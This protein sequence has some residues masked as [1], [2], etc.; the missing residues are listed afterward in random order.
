MIVE[1]NPEELMEQKQLAQEDDSAIAKNDPLYIEEII[2]NFEGRRLETWKGQEPD[3]DILKIYLEEAK[4]LIDSSS[5]HLQEFRSNNSDLAA[6]Q[7]LQRELHTIKGGARM[8][9]AEGIATL[10]HEM[11]T[12]YEEL[13][14]R[15]KPATRMI[16]NLLA[17]CHDWLA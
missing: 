7:A 13:G 5:Q 6:L 1:A 16:G 12:I 4:E 14:S 3:E 2:N 17:V 10:A 8:V 15:R 11:E 9:G